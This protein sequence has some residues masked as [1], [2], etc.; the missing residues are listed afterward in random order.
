MA[1][2]SASGDDVHVLILAEGQTARDVDPSTPQAR[3]IV[4]SLRDAAAAA[5]AIVGA[6]DPIFGGLPDNRMDGVDLL[7]VVRLVEAALSETHA[8]IV[9]THHAGDLN[10]DHMVTN[11]AV[12]VACRPLP[13]SVVRSIYGFE[14]LSSTEW[15]GP[16]GEPF[17]PQ[18]FVDLTGYLEKK[19]A[20]LD[21][22]RQ[23]MRDFPHPRST[24][25]VRALA[26]FRGA[27]SG[28]EAAEAFQVIR[29]IT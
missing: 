1:R 13:G 24:E 15:A 22:Y 9:Y 12:R 25:A 17:E 10:Q 23:E 8:E 2:H 4:A 6:T 27:S 29:E 3:H 20:A 19:I 5:A 18:R 14:N 28:L 26:A 7:D 16:G 11:H 21:A